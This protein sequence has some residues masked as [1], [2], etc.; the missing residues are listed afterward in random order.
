MQSLYKNNLGV[1]SFAIMLL[2]LIVLTVV[3]VNGI[4]I[5][6]RNNEQANAGLKS[7]E[8]IA[9]D[10]CLQSHEIF[11]EQCK[12]SRV[13]KCNEYFILR[14]GCIGV[15]DVIIN[16]KGEYINWCGYTSLEGQTP[17]CGQYWIDVYG[18]D[19]TENNNL[20]LNI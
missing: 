19:C 11:P 18:N 16:N 1:S 6:M 4:A 12:I 15:G 2:A 7:G 20:C 8:Q 5:S 10:Y 14:T 13:Y 9:T 17:E 3:L